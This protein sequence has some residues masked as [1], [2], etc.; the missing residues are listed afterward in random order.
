MAPANDG[1][2]NEGRIYTVIKNVTKNSKIVLSTLNGIEVGPGQSLDL[3]TSF[4]KAQVIDAA[5]EIASL[6]KSGHVQDIG[7]GAERGPEPVASAGAPTQ[8]E[9]KK[10]M[11]E[12]MLRE[13]SDSTNMSALE[14]WVNSK[15]ADVSRAAKLRVDV[16]LG[17]RDE[18]TGDLLPGA[19]EAPA[20]PTELIRSGAPGANQQPVAAGRVHRA[21]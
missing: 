12:A 8:D 10:K 2:D 9:M 21:E 17:N 16:L 14:D 20:T 19:E 3:R 18:Q 5:H 13:V 1:W 15:D 6:I 4:R 11:K 7:E